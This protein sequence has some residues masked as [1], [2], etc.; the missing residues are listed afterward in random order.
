MTEEKFFFIL[1]AFLAGSELENNKWV[2]AGQG[3]NYEHDNVNSE[4]YF[5]SRLKMRITL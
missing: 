4:G 5:H 2:S 1:T 3:L